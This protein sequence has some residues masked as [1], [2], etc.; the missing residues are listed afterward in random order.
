VKSNRENA[1]GMLQK[2]GSGVLLHVTSL[3]SRHG[4]GDLGPAAHTFVDFLARAK[5]SYWQVLP[6]TPVSDAQE[7]SPYNC[8][9][10]FAGNKYLISIELMMHEGLVRKS[11]IG[12]RPGPSYRIVDFPAVVAYKNRIFE[13]AYER[14]KSKS[15]HGEYD[16]FCETNKS[17][18]DDFAFF[19]VLKGHFQ[20]RTWTDWPLPA[21][22]RHKRIFHTLK[23]SLKEHIEREKFL[24]YIFAKQW[25]ALKKYCN[26]NGIS[27]IGDIPMYVGFDSAD[28]WSHPELFKLDKDKRPTRV[29]GVPPDY[30]SADGQLWGN[31]V[32]RWDMLRKTDYQW[33]L[34][35]V[36]HDLRLFDFV[37]MDH[38]RGFVACWEVP[39][40]A[41][42]ARR[43][44]WKKAPA[45][46]FLATLEKK[47]HR[48]PIIAEDLGTITPKV[49]DIV[50]RFGLPGMRVLLFA[51][52]DGMWT[53]PYLPHNHV[54]HCV[55]Y[56]GTH[57]NNTVRGW[58]ENEASKV[59]KQR[60]FAYLGTKVSARHVHESFVRMAMMSVANTVIIPMQDILGLGSESRMNRP[61]SVDG[62]WQ[63]R[64]M[65]GYLK[66]SVASRLRTMTEIFGRA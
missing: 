13:N 36:A 65:P 38:F 10:A 11:D 24:Q 25:M 14:F 47:L 16:A 3:P 21:I 39:F 2:R 41:K 50:E 44:E 32:Y 19:T 56:T 51:F 37:R 1:G 49:R 31:P 12:S 64:L 18:L 58:F 55:V 61:A 45:A 29:S 28:V 9:S 6:L 59:E 40:G 63:W 30:F 33:W 22:H 46:H 4:I 42:T 52:G 35:R 57:D 20:N 53:N 66:P 62:N 34:N 43:G 27:V 7:Y 26:N 54:N 5:Q 48:L 23:N 60:L 15:G 8:T 17:W